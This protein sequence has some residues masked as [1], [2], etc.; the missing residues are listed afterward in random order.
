[1][2]D[3]ENLYVQLGH[4][5]ALVPDFAAPDR[6]CGCCRRG[7]RGGRF[8]RPAGV[9]PGRS[10]LTPLGTATTACFWVLTR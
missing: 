6:C 3:P 2:I 5:L 7:D 9:L 4:L 8:M 1:M 10:L